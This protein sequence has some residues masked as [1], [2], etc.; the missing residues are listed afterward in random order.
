MRL[1]R[2]AK[3]VESEAFQAAVHACNANGDRYDESLYLPAK[4][5]MNL[6]TPV[7]ALAALFCVM[8]VKCARAVD[9]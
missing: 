7:R 1:V 5:T 6:K 9:F 8:Q 3:C 2:T 4:N